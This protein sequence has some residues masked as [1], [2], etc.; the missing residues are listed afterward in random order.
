MVYEPPQGNFGIGDS[1]VPSSS[2]S[3][4]D[5]ASKLHS[6]SPALSDFNSLSLVLDKFDP[7][8]K[9]PGNIKSVGEFVLI[10]VL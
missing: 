6:G 9:V 8:V 2:A 5:H 10:F 7:Y 3:D 1:V 4:R